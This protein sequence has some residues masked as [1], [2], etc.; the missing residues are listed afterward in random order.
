MKLIIEEKK[1]AIVLDFFA[2]SG[3]TGHAVL[4][5]NRQDGGNRQFILCTNNEKEDGNIADN[6]TTKRLKRIMA[7]KCYDGTNEFKWLEKNEPYGGALDV[8]NIEQV[9]SFANASPCPLEVI[10]EENYDLK[11]NNETDRIDWI[12]QNFHITQ[13]S[14]PPCPTGGNNA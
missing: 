2:G 13:K 7:G 11:F 6:V 5:L 8:Y 9:S 3:T 10:K 4:E 14:V 12:C 1:E